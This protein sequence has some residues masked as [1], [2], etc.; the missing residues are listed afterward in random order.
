[1]ADKLKLLIIEDD[2]SIATQMKWALAQNYEIFLAE[3]RASAL[4]ILGKERPHVVTLDLG[5][6]PNP[7]E[8]QEG[9]LA[10]AEMLS[11]DG[12][13]KG[14]CYHRPGGEGACFKSDRGGGLRLFLQTHSNRRAQSGFKPGLLCLSA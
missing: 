10:L 6:P 11:Q 4:E 12:L 7:G 1:M 5:L 2:S 9:F 3:D 14:N 8:V 13:S